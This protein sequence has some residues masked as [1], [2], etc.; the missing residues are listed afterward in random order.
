MRAAV[1]TP[2][3]IAARSARRVLSP[4]RPLCPPSPP[5]H[6]PYELDGFYDEAFA[7]PDTARPGYAELLRALSGPYLAPLAANVRV[8]LSLRGVTFGGG[9]DAQVFPV[10][11]VPRVLLGREWRLLERGLAQRVRALQAFVADVYGERSIVAAGRVPARVVDSADHLEPWAESIRV[12]PWLYAP[13]AGI[14]VVRGLDGRLAVLEDNL[15]TPSGIAFMLAAREV[16]APRL[17]VA[18]PAA[19][20]A[21]GSAVEAL[22]AALRAAAPGGD[23]LA[24][25][26]SDGPAN[27]A[28]YE[29]RTLA[30]LLD[31]PLITPSE[32]YLRRGRV[33]ALVD[34]RARE[35]AVVYRRTDEDRLRD[36]RGRRTWVARM[37][38]DP[39]R[40]GRVTCVNGFGGGVGDDKL[41]HAYVEEMIRFYLH[42]EPLLPSVRT[43][44]LGEP[45]GRQEALARIDEL[46]LK[47]RAGHGG[48]GIVV[49]P[50]ARPEDLR[51]A[52]RRVR[53]NREDWVAQETVLLSRHPTV[54]GARLVPRHV[55]LRVFVLTA[56]G[57]PRVAP[58]GL[59]RYARRPG[60]LIVN[61]SAG[62]GAKDTWVLS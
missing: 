17:R 43:Y 54:A 39:C 24:V 49:G 59:T 16:V 28:W 58:G 44:D 26:L 56:D 45:D 32:L 60:S 35:V 6:A 15:R 55:D 10:D 50:H 13:V 14:D 29:H 27:S 21:P 23:G 30:R 38:L 12:A 25:L 7:G 51:E 33:R 42:E 34:G 61:S 48:Y 40:H 36:E 11:P 47:P 57:V 19:L 20:R 18:P 8:A 31:V 37:L 22:G 46:V 62:G 52:A 3:R 41:V 9:P 5:V 2:L 4:V 53:A 1:A